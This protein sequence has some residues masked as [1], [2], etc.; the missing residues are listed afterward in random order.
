M[1]NDVTT[2]YWF[3]NHKAKYETIGYP[4]T[5]AAVEV[6]KADIFRVHRMIRAGYFPPRPPGSN[7]A[8]PL[9]DL[10]GKAGLERAWSSLRDV[11]ELADYR[12]KYGD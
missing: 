12:A 5:D 9:I 3:V 2:R 11:P 8:N 7:W 10:I 4:L 1:G 6:L